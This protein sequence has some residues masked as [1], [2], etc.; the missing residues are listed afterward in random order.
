MLA[1]CIANQTKSYFEA[2]S[3]CAMRSYGTHGTAELRQALI[4]RRDRRSNGTPP[5]VPAKD[6]PLRKGCS[7][8]T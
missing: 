2:L 3:M 8:S 6:D 7:R 1:M 4:C 5:L